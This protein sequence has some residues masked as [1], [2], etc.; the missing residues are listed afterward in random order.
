MAREECGQRRLE[1]VLKEKEKKDGL[2]MEW[3]DPGEGNDREQ[4]AVGM[5]SKKDSGL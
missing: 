2:A 3:Q 4:R 5:K 1:Q